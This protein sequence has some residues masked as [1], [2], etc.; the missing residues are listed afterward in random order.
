MRFD[1]ETG[2]PMCMCGE[3]PEAIQRYW[4]LIADGETPGI[5]SIGA[6]KKILSVRGESSFFSGQGDLT[7]LG[8]EEY[9]KNAYAK[10]KRAGVV[11]TGKIYNPSIAGEAGA[12]DPDAWISMA[13]GGRS[14]FRRVCEKRGYACP[15]LGIKANG[16]LADNQKPDKKLADHLAKRLYNEA[17]AENPGLARRPV[18]EVTSELVDANVA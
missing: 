6:T 13:E 8:G 16:K 1:E 9:A 12:A 17:V 11:T 2:L 14:H 5:A 10:A 3:S 4:R 7:R 15:E 18:A